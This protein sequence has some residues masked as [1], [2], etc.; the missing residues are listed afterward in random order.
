MYRT[1]GLLSEHGVID[2]LAHRQGE[3][4][5]RLCGGAHHHHLVCSD[6]HRV[7]ELAECD[8][9]PR[10]EKL[11]ASHGFTVTEHSVEAV[12]LCADCRAA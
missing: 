1:L 10:L 7:V 2:S 12:G 3:T 9:G 11:G 5:Y 6:C 8:L 4:C